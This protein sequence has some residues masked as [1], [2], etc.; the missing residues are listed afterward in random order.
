MAGRREEKKERTKAAILEAALKLFTKNGFEN[1]S[2]DDLASAA[3]IGKGTVYSYFRSKSEIFLA[4]CEEQLV[5]V[6]RELA[7]KSAPG[8]PL[9]QQL[10]T[11]FMGEFRFISDNREFGRILMRETIF[12]KELTV[13]RSGDLHD[14]YIELLVPLF[15]QA[16]QRGELR[17][18]LELILVVGHF[19]GLYTMTV[20]GWYMGRLLTDEDVY[21][22]LEILFEQ[23]LHGLAPEKKGGKA[24]GQA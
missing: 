12:P 18:D 1:T 7:E 14:K 9:L 4:F 10:L 24:D 11:L 5:Y 21:M 23:A 6:D 13:D 22:T 2:I 3:G 19:Y 15:K 8:A 20:S 16:Q 17:R